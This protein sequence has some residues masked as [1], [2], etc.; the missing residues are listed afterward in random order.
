[1]VL[2]GGLQS[3]SHTELGDCGLAWQLALLELR[4]MFLP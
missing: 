4:G 1:M 3:L 2:P